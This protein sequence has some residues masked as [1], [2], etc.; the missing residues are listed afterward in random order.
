MY[1]DRLEIESPGCLPDVVTVNNIRETRF[2]RNPKIS[3]VLTEFGWVR[4]L[5][6][7]V[8][9]IF[10]DMSEGKLEPPVYSDHANTVHLILKNSIDE[11]TAYRNKILNESI[12]FNSFI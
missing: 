12:K 11:R 6:E 4:E 10:T 7:G 9:K 1:D 5:N 2:S 8:K 3:R